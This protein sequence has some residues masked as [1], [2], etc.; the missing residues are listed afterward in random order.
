MEYP[1]VHDTNLW[2]DF[3]DF[4]FQFCFSQARL[5]IEELYDFPQQEA[6]RSHIG[7]IK[8][9]GKIKAPVNFQPIGN[10]QNHNK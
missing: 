9:S 6:N 3:H 2:K 4:S 10:F 8:S 5:Q 7:S 1:R